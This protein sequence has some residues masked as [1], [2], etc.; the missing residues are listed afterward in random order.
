MWSPDR[1]K[2]FWSGPPT[3]TPVRSSPQCRLH[4]VART[5]EMVGRSFARPEFRGRQ[6]CKVLVRRLETPCDAGH[7]A[8]VR[9]ELELQSESMAF[10]GHR[11]A[12]VLREK[13]LARLTEIRAGFFRLCRIANRSSCK[14]GQERDRVVAS[15]SGEFSG[16]VVCPV[17]V[18]D[19]V[20]VHEYGRDAR[21]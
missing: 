14:D 9:L 16:E 3:P 5:V 4:H 20:A 8:S 21:T 13:F 7:V 15:P 2:R 11:A 1:R 19:L 18:A 6:V 12:V 10:G 17:L